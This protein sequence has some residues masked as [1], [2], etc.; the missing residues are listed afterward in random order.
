MHRRVLVRVC[1]LGLSTA[2]PISTSFDCSNAHDDTDCDAWAKSG[3][4][5]A[6]P[7]FMRAQCARSCGSCGWRNTYCDKR[8]N[9]PAKAN[10][11]IVRTFERAIALPGLNAVVHSVDPYVVTFDNFISDEE[12]D[13]FLSTTQG[14]FDRSLAGDMVSPVRTSKQVDSWIQS[15]L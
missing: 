9:G 7:D 11:E 6:N 2:A 12:A 1:F 10:G 5:A 3:E 4:C 14:H 15:N 13:A 8:N